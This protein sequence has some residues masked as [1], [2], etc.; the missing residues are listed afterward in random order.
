MTIERIGHYFDAATILIRRV[1]ASLSSLERL[2]HLS[3]E[4][5]CLSS[6]GVSGLSTFG[7]NVPVSMSHS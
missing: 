2:L 6:I 1:P 7:S 4:G 5:H 3:F